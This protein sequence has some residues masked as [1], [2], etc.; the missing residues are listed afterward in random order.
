MSLLAELAPGATLE[1]AS[2]DEA[3]L[4]RA[5]AGE[6]ARSVL[7]RCSLARSPSPGDCPEGPQTPS[8]TLRSPPTNPQPSK[9]QQDITA[10]ARQQLSALEAAG[11]GG[12]ADALRDVA[13]CSTIVGDSGLSAD[14]ALDRLLAVGALARP[15]CC[16]VPALLPPSLSPFCTFLRFFIRPLPPACL[17]PTTSRPTTSFHLRPGGL[18]AARL[19]AGVAA[20]LEYTMS[21]GVAANKLVAKIGSALHKPDAQTLVPQRAVPGLMAVRRGSWRCRGSWRWS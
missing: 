19:R 10:M 8:Q 9:P 5:V 15:S 3:Y 2:I 18:I 13:A 20:R 14:S 6:G 11:G 7:P 1:K 21:A 16:V 12:V 17:L 4:A